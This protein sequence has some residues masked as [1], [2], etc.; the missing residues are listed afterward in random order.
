[1]NSFVI[2][3]FCN[4]GITCEDFTK[5]LKEKIQDHGIEIPGPI[6]GLNLHELM[7]EDNTP[8][9]GL[10]N[11]NFKQII[12]EDG[13]RTE[14][15]LDSKFVVN[16]IF[17]KIHDSKMKINVNFCSTMNKRRQIRKRRQNMMQLLREPFEKIVQEHLET[18]C[19]VQN[20]NS[21]SYL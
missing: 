21:W 5:T 10:M 8:S 11:E 2:V 1:M 3:N 14:I 12:F 15:S 16:E 4:R 13:H 9:A 18:V 7:K 20:E 19:V 6:N 17:R